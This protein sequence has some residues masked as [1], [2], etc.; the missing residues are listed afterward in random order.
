MITPQLVAEALLKALPTIAYE[1][2]PDYLAALERALA[3]ADPR[4]REAQVLEILVHNDRFAKERGLPLCQDTGTVWVS[5]EVG[6]EETLAGNPFALADEVV[7]RAYKEGLLRMSVVHDALVD[8]TNTKTNTPVF[9]ELA[10]RPGRG[11]TLHVMLKGGGSDNASKLLM[12]PPGAGRAGIVDF[13]L[14][15]V[16]EKASSAC[17]PLVVGIGVGG[18]FDTVGA[19]AKHQ[20]LRP[21]ASKNP[22][23]EIAAFEEELLARINA[24]GI[25]PSGLGG[26][27]TALSVLVGTAPCHIAALP[28]AINMGCSALRTATIEVVGADE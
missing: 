18:T 7:A 4:S 25:G 20:L 10:F 13:V 14:Q 3:Q 11:A 5:L 22:N 8:R 24:L 9:T 1:V 16:R 26:K 15:T 2:R 17:P 27:T 21:L 28:V 23:P 19:L 6:E 12:L